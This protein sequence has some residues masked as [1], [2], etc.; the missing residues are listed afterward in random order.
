MGKVKTRTAI[1][2][3]AR[4]LQNQGYSIGF[5]SGVFDLFHNTHLQFLLE[6]KTL[7]DILVI[8][9]NTDRSV[10]EYKS[11]TRPIISESDR[12]NIVAALEC[13]DYAF[14]FDEP[15]NNKN[16]EIIH[17]DIYMKG[18][19]YTRDGLTSKELIEA[20][21]GKTALVGTVGP[22]TTE[23]IEKILERYKDVNSRYWNSGK[24]KK[25]SD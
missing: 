22:G 20:Y 9:V 17:P 3:I 6:A 10:Q 21:G 8:G 16:I 18:S 4:S 14:L 7:C 24:R 5:I 1:A 23:I 19:D 15:N 11:P 2:G 25:L 12:I 13:V